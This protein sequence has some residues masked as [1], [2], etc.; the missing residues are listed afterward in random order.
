MHAVM[1]QHPTDCSD[2]SGS[3]T[4]PVT[5]TS[6]GVTW[7]Y[8]MTLAEFEALEVPS[9]H[10]ER[11]AAMR[12]LEGKL[13]SADLSGTGLEKITPEHEMAQP[14]NLTTPGVYARTVLL[15]A[16]LRVFGKRHAQEHINIVSCGRATVMTEEGKQEVIGPCQFVSPAGTK[17]FLHV[18]EDM[19]WTVV[20]RVSSADM[21]EIEAELIIAER[22]V[23]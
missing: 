8:R 16:G 1:S 2:T 7:P 15:P 13:W 18:H 4:S 9:I 21:E 22:L 17:R 20:S 23:A 3:N 12:E 10:R 14:L 6:I 19:V 5:S 11:R